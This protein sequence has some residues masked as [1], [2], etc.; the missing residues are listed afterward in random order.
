MS[1]HKEELWSKN[2]TVIPGFLDSCSAK[3]LSD[4]FRE[5]AD[6]EGLTGDSQTEE[7][8]SVYNYLPFLEILCQKCPEVSIAIGETVLPTYTYA[9]VY[10]NGAVLKGHTDRDACEISLTVNLD[11]DQE[12][13]IW[14]ETPDGKEVRVS[15]NPGDAM[16]Y[17]GCTARHWREE[18]KGDWYTQCF[19]HYVRSRGDKAHAVFDSQ[20]K[21]TPNIGVKNYLNHKEVLEEERIIEETPKVSDNM[22]IVISEDGLE[23]LQ[24]KKVVEVFKE[25]GTNTLEQY[26]KVF[27]D[28]VPEDLC[29]AIIKEYSN[30]DEWRLAETGGGLQTEVRNVDEISMSSDESIGNSSLRRELDDRLF[31]SVSSVSKKYQEEFKHYSINVD[32]GYQLLRYKEG[33]FYTQHTDSFITQQRSLS[34]SLILNDDYEGG[35]FCF[36]DGTMMHRPPKGAA[37]VFPSNFMYPHEIRKVTKGERYSI[38]TWLV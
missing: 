8:Q 12:W 35:E 6:R 24:E 13:P 23:M 22:E 5:F 11:G 15:L 9:R 36:W 28:V 18:Y 4:E 38:I 27:Y 17:L 29:D 20:N 19:L 25:A 3:E 14:I 2:Y 21:N 34:C 10:K 16:I 26:V 30:S 7:S 32:T 33:Q 31:E 1:Q 37:L